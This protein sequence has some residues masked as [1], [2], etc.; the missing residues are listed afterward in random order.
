MHVMTG[1]EHSTSILAVMGVKRRRL[2]SG[3][4]QAELAERA[5][6][7]RQLVAAVE[8]GRHAPAVDA[9]LGLARALGTSVEELFTEPGGSVPELVPALAERL[10]DGAPVKVG[11]VG[12][13]VVAAELPDHGVAG[14]GWA[15]PDGVVDGG[16][17]RLFAGASPAGL[18]VAGCDPAFGVAERMLGGLGPRSVLA[19]GAPTGLA[20][21]ALERGRIDAG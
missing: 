16:E 11:R 20:L 15:E 12:K 8:A 10:P 4:T 21:K 19:I 1:S 7:S 9:A 6:V 2:E 5:G 3:L 17:L 13:R 18:V 14:T